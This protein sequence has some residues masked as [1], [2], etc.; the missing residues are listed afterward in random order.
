VGCLALAAGAIL[1]VIGEI[2]P[3]GRR[4]S[5]ELTLWGLAAGFLIGVIT[6]LVVAAA[7]G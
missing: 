4:L 3:V 7:G 5:W 2:V 1:Y 6:D